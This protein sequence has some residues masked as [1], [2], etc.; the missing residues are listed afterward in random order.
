V[1]ETLRRQLIDI[2]ET[3]AISGVAV[4]SHEGSLWV[5]AP[6]EGRDGQY[7]IY[8]VTKVFIALTYLR[9]ADRGVLGLDDPVSA[10]LDIDLPHGVTLRRLLNHT[11][12]IPD[13]GRLPEYHEAVRAH[14][15]VPWTDEEFLSRTL[16]RGLDSEP[17]REFNYSNTGYLLL[18]CL[19]D[20]ATPGGCWAAIREQV[21]EPLGLVGTSLPKTLQDLMPLVPSE[22]RLLGADVTDVR[23]I[24]HPHWVGHR[25]LASTA[26]DL[27]HLAQALTSTQLLSR[28]RVLEMLTGV[29][30]SV[31]SHPFSRPA[32]GLGVMMDRRGKGQGIVGHLGSGPGYGAAMFQSYNSR[33]APIIVSVLSNRDGSPHIE[34]VALAL[35]AAAEHHFLETG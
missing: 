15:G 34:G 19:L 32:Y 35:L 23:G 7:L 21:I 8:S 33:R 11:A 14:P 1:D 9:L 31:K 6:E 24:Y 2:W 29:D 17:G 26:C 13:Y 25:V 30:V 12:G 27:A 3:A 18:R 28:E 5:G 22:T 16:K 4:V 10:W 20:R